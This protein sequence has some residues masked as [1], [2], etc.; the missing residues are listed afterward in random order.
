MFSLFINDLVLF[1]I[2]SLSNYAGDN[3]YNTEKDIELVKSVLEKDFRTVTDWFYE[4]CMIL[5]PNKSHCIG[6]RKKT[7]GDKFKL[8]NVCL[9][10]SKEVVFVGITIDK[11]LFFDSHIKNTCQKAGQKLSAISRI[12]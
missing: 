11:K 1:I 2:L 7:K 8:N 9:G 4:N 5:N 3:S 6:I 12:S 10:Y